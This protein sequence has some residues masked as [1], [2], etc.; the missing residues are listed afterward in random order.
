MSEITGNHR[1]V[2]VDY[3]KGDSKPTCLIYVPM[4]SSY[5]YKALGDFGS[6]HAKSRPTKDRSHYLTER[7]KFNRQQENNAIVNSAVD[8]ILP[9]EKQKASA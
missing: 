1:K 8:E 3:P 6:K 9:Q 2:Y 5:R 4:Y 7:N